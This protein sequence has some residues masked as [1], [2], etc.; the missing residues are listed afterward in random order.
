MEDSRQ[1]YKGCNYLIQGTC[2]DMTKIFEINI[3]N[4][5]RKNNLG[6][7]MVLPIHDEIIFLVPYGEE[8]YVKDLKHIMEDTLDVIKNIPMVAS[9]DYSETN[10]AEK[11]EYEITN[12]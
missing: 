5:I 7:K 10:W 2:A 8:K 11:V 6:I 4:F 1:F 9:V 3:Y 12:D